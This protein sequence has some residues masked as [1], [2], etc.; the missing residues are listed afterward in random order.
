MV[1]Q[2]THK[3]DKEFPG[4]HQ[5]TGLMMDTPSIDPQMLSQLKMTHTSQLFGLIDHTQTNIFK[6]SE[7]P[8]KYCLYDLKCK[9]LIGNH[10]I[11]T[12]TS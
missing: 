12:S 7:T 3:L 11:K 5:P 8:V 4:P 1:A 10:I 9:V 6:F 2:L